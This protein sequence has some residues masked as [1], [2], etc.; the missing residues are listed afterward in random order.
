MLVSDLLTEAPRKKASEPSW[1]DDYESG[2]R[3]LKDFQSV[4]WNNYNSKFPLQLFV[5]KRRDPKV[6]AELA[7]RRRVW[8]VAQELSDASKSKLKEEAPPVLT[9]FSEA[10]P[11]QSKPQDGFWTSSAIE[12]SKGWT[13]DWYR[14]VEQTFPTWQTDYGYLF[15]VK[16]NAV[17][18]DLSY[19]DDFFMWA[20]KVGHVKLTQDEEQE[21]F[22]RDSWV[23]RAKFPWDLLSRHFDGAHHSGHSDHGFTYGWDVE[24]TVWFNTKCLNYKGAVKLASTNEDEE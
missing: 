22:R 11:G 24:S 17:V 13:S 5:P 10:P 1:A 20:V 4:R 15:E 2:Y 6:M 19:A 8:Q 3:E 14:L 21:A 7:T 23:I 9:S 18:F 12:K 16:S